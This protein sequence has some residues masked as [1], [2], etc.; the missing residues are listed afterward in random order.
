MLSRDMEQSG[1][2]EDTGLNQDLPR[3]GTRHNLVWRTS[4][5]RPTRKRIRVQRLRTA[6]PSSCQSQQCRACHRWKQRIISTCRCGLLNEHGAASQGGLSVSSVGSSKPREEKERKEQRQARLR[7]SL[8]VHPGRG[9]CLPVGERQRKQ[10]P[11]QWQGIW[12]KEEPE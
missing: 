4:I 5:H 10:E 2:V 8:H 3:H 7:S 1:P 11:Q 6:A 9:Q 12:P